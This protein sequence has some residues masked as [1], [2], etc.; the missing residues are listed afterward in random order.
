MYTAAIRFI[1]LPPKNR[2]MNYAF[3]KQLARITGSVAGAVALG[4]GVIFLA[5]V[6]PGGSGILASLRL[7]DGS[8]YMISQRCN[9]SAEPYTVSFF[10]RSPGGAWGWCYVDHEATRW[11][12]VAMTYNV[13]ADVVLIAERGTIRASLDRKRNAFWIDNGSINRESDAP[14]SFRQPEYAFR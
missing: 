10:M 12:D 14:N 9:W 7:P 13:A 1:E 4:C 3:F 8:E 5:I 11:K 6:Q 2:A